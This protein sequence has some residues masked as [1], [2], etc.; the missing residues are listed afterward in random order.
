VSINQHEFVSNR[1]SRSKLG[2]VESRVEFTVPLIGRSIHRVDDGANVWSPLTRGG[3]HSIHIRHASAFPSRDRPSTASSTRHCS[4]AAVSVGPALEAVL[5]LLLDGAPAE[6]SLVVRGCG[7]RGGLGVGALVGRTSVRAD[8]ESTVDEHGDGGARRRR[9]QH[10]HERTTRRDSRRQRATPD[11]ALTTLA[12]FTVRVAWE[13]VVRSVRR[14]IS[15]VARPS[16]TRSRR[17]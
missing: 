12:P 10:D 16:T 9:P 7:R 6:Q 4:A 1:V 17:V 14:P 15:V 3:L 11:A 2:R 13:R 8:V 5:R